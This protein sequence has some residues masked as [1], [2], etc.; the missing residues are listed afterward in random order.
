MIGFH[1]R[2]QQRQ[3][4]TR[5]PEPFD[6]RFRRFLKT[7]PV[8]ALML[9]QAIT[10]YILLQS[11]FFYGLLFVLLLYMGGVFLRHFF[12]D[13]V[14][15]AIYLSGGAAGFVAY[16]LMFQ[17]PL[18]QPD[19]LHIAAAQA[20]AVFALLTFVSVAKPDLRLRMLLLLQIRFWHIA[21]PLMI[22]ALLRNDLAGGGTH[23]AATAGAA[24]AAAIALI[25]TRK[26]LKNITKRFT[27]YREK[28]KRTRFAK[29][30]T[31]KEGGRPLRDEEYNDIRA[32]RQKRIDGILDKISVSGYDSLS[33]E[34]KEL[35][36]KQSDS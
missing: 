1:D 26:V 4:F 32:E 8:L 13:W 20:S 29:Y 30:S 24:L 21:I 27:Q 34:E 16:G 12:N 25:T 17:H 2:F 18:A 14:L 6:Q 11:G 15:L 9:A 33:R 31:V 36:F 35:L 19:N 3:R 10:T 5:S 7:Q 22:I 28:K 23:L